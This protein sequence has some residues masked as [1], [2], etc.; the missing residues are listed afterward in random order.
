MHNT[1]QVGTS[2]LVSLLLTSLFAVA[3]Y[4]GAFKKWNTVSGEG[5]AGDLGFILGFGLIVV[6]P[7]VMI[8]NGIFGLWE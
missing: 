5:F 1:A 8:I 7:V 2:A 6:L 4:A 3:V